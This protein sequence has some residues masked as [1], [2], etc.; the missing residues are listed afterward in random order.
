[1]DV[2]TF[3]IKIDATLGSYLASMLVSS[4]LPNFNFEKASN[5]IMT[6]IESL[7]SGSI[8][9]RLL[10]LAGMEIG[11]YIMEVIIFILAA[12]TSE[13]VFA[14]QG[15]KEG[16]IVW[17]MRYSYTG[18]NLMVDIIN[19]FL[20]GSFSTFV[21]RMYNF[22]SNFALSTGGNSNEGFVDYVW[23]YLS[24]W[25]KIGWA[26]G[27]AASI[28]LM[29]LS[30]STYLYVRIAAYTGMV[31]LM[32]YHAYQDYSDCDSYVGFY[33]ACGGSSPPPGMN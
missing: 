10:D 31:A 21:S 28:A 1:M 12:V 19:Y 24:S 22:A 9:L 8:G 11:N 6:A 5:K 20:S 13:A 27:L 14:S 3:P 16:A 33:T 2:K 7:K 17:A 29:I 25:E 23:S 4:N 26:V 32:A 15:A 18:T 30:G